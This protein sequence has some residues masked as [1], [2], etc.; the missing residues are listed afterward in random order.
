MEPD[1]LAANRWALSLRGCAAIVFG[2]LVLVWPNVTLDALV[3]L[4]GAYVLLEGVFHVAAGVRDRAEHRSCGASIFAGL[5]STVAGVVTLAL[6][7]PTELAVLGVVG[8]WALV[9]GISETVAGMRF[10]RRFDGGASL[11]LNGILSTAF[12]ILTIL[13]TEISVAS[14]AWLIG[15]YAFAFGALVLAAAFRLRYWTTSAVT[16]TIVLSGLLAAD[17]AAHR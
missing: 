9:I 11:V 5:V 8:V 10:R 17:P 3:V 13:I 1:E 6:H 7:R 2:V 4:L 12:G 16:P 15:A 14:L